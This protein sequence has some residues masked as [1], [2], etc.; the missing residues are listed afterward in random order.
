[1]KDIDNINHVGIV[2]RDLAKTA[3]RYESFGFLLTPFS[4]HSG[5]WNPTETVQPLASGNRCVM[6]GNNYLEILASENPAEPSP[7]ME[8]Y[9]K[10]HQGAHIICFNSENL[11]SVDRRLAS[12]GIK[13]SGIIPLQ[14][15]IDTPS[16]MQTAK[17]ERIQF[18]PDDSPEGY[19][20]AANHLTPQHI[21]QRRYIT[22]PNGCSG[23]TDAIVIADDL[24]HFVEKYSRYADA[25]PRWDGE[26][27][28]FTFPLGARLVLASSKR[29]R[30][31]LP[32]TLFPPLPGIAAVAFH[33]PDL[34]AQRERLERAAVIFAETPR[35]L[36][37][38][39]EEASGIAV[40]FESKR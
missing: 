20:Q 6:F 22:H 15:E 23:L 33:T 32:G 28:S 27:A 37:I 26:A 8:S 9:L 21:Y 5:A 18:A 3:A 30:E 39:A 4:V 25:E 12:A 19:I 2:V 35:G 40:I 24:R 13:T 36:I 11:T 17:F 34:G 31:L 38:P 16:G 14:R 29:G 10:R 7:R 1:L